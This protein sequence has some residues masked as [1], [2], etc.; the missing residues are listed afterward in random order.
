[1]RASNHH[2]AQVMEEYHL[3][4]YPLLRIIDESYSETAGREPCIDHATFVALYTSRD[5]FIA[6]WERLGLQALAPILT[7]RYP[8]EHIALIESAKPYASCESMIGLS[9]SRDPRSPINEFVERHAM[10]ARKTSMPGSL[11]HVAV[12]LDPTVD[13]EAFVAHL[14]QKNIAFMTPLLR[15]IQDSRTEL[16]QIFTAS[17][18]PYGWFVELIQRKNLPQLPANAPEEELFNYKQIDNL[19]AHY[20][21]HSKTLKGTIRK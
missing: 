19:Y 1:M 11:Q 2:M 16:K 5:A 18:L 12:N 8:A 3:G 17:N 20:D 15:T 6:H 13:M 21:R 10:G 9:V 7:E 4:D 14:E